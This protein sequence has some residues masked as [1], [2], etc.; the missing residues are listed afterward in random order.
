MFV[1]HRRCSGS[2]KTGTGLRDKGQNGTAQ[3]PHTHSH[4]FYPTAGEEEPASG[5]KQFK[6]QDPAWQ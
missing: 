6:P 5:K 4:V 3:P 1:S 2:R